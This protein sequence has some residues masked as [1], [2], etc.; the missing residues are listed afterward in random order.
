MT[1]LIALDALSIDYQTPS[2]PVHAVRDLN[3]TIRRGETWGLVG[4]SGSGK[5]TLVSSMMALLPTNARATGALRF[6]GR[7]LLAMS[8]SDRRQLRGN[9]IAAIFQDPFTA[10]N[11]IVSIGA[12]LVEVQ[13]H[14]RDRSRKDRR[15]RAMAMLTR[16]GISDAEKRMRQFPFEL[17]GGMRQRV[18]I[19][20]ALLTDP[21]LLIADEPTTALDAT[22]EAQIVDLL[23]RTRSEID[24]AI[25]F[26][27]H[28]LGLVAELCD[29]AAVM[30][31]G[32]IVESG[33]VET[34]FARPRHP[35]TRALLECD[36]A[37]LHT[38]TRTLPTIRG[39]IPNLSELR[40]GC[41]FAPRCVEAGAICATAPPPFVAGVEGGAAYCHR[42]LA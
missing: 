30:Y 36:P 13:H 29:H 23:R 21:V 32:E 20:A 6:D 15:D 35:Y 38:A 25:V 28:H 34:L 8:E 24:G 19:A 12:L 27:T 3:L 31:A 7:D 42:P 26:V 10:L 2:G 5:S 14:K 17:S 18:A 22:T 1:P 37:L 40:A 33:P 4:E 11:P 16:V 39:S 41:S 9:G